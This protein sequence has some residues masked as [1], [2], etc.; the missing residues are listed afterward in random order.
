MVFSP[1]PAWATSTLTI[2]GDYLNYEYIHNSTVADNLDD[3]ELARVKV[4]AADWVFA[5]YANTSASGNNE[6]DHI[7]VIAGRT[8]A[9]R[10]L[11][12]FYT[13][14][15]TQGDSDKMTLLFGGFEP[16]IGFAALAELVSP[17]NAAFY[18]LPEP[19]SSLMFELFALREND[20][21]TYPD[22]DELYVRF[23]YQNGTDEDST[24]AEYPL[25]G[26][27]PSLTMMSLSDFIAG[28]ERIMVY[29]VEGMVRNLQQL[30]HLL[31]GFHQ[32]KRCLE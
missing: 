2:S 7:G 13:T 5:M 32:F 19:G 8:L 23:L 9:A 27:S 4:L 10:I 28:I 29:N 16:M 21:G 30:Q 18:N 26:R 3:I 25:F 14:I 20:I 17:Q 24:A 22:F 12:A 11:Q 15:N 31:S 1:T 6:G